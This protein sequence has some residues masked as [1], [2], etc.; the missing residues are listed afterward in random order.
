ME[1]SGG[2]GGI[3]LKNVQDRIVLGFGK[4]YGLTVYSKKGC[5][6]KVRIRIPLNQE[7]EAKD[8]GAEGSQG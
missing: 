2:K 3:G 8:A 5:Y 7:K 6:T 1:P 4:K